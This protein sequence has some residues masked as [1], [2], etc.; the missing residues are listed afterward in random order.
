[1]PRVYFSHCINLKRG[2]N[3]KE[4]I[5]S[6]RWARGTAC[7]EVP[8]VIPRY[9]EANALAGQKFRVAVSIWRVLHPNFKED[10][11]KYARKYQA[12]HGVDGKQ[13]MSGFNAYM[14]GILKVPRP[15][16]T[17]TEIRAELGSNVFEW[18]DNGFLPNV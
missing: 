14:K 17:L 2:K 13:A 18:Y 1:M 15:M 8:Y 9:H 11:L 3:K 6:K 7:L 10:L 16:T 5:V 4:K 12:R